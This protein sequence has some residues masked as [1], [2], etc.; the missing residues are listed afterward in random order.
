MSCIKKTLVILWAAIGLSMALSMPADAGIIHLADI[1]SE[2]L[3]SNPELASARQNIEALSHRPDQSAALPNPMLSLGLMNVPTDSFSFDNEAMTQKSI[4]LSQRFPWSG[5]RQLKRE[6]AEKDLLKG[7]FA[8]KSLEL[9]LVLEVKRSYFQLFM[10]NRA[11]EI[12]EKN[13]RLLKELVGIAETKYSVGKGIQQDVL[14]A[15]VELSRMRDR[16]ITLE[17]D[18]NTLKA[19]LNSLMNRLPQEQLGDPEELEL[20]ETDPDLER[21]QNLASERHPLL[22]AVEADVEG[23]RKENLLARKE[24]K[25]D[26]DLSMQYGQRDDGPM[27]ERPDFVSAV[28]KFSVPLWRGEKED[29]R[30]LETAARVKQGEREYDRIRNRLFF[31]AARLKEGLESRRERA[32]LFKEGIIPQ[33]KAS[34]DS[35]VAGYQVNKVDFLTLLSSQITLFNYEMEYY[36]SVSEHEIKL[37]ELEEV[38]GGD[39]AAI[40]EKMRGKKNE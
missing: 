18:R 5:K 15:Q 31:E 35:S 20:T 4:V 3:K 9:K 36:K 40:P 8:L 21:V 29:R 7:E 1:I 39:I 38:A 22:K 14:K 34:L 10:A 33:A 26:I 6:M 28:V 25:P 16:L 27:G 17:E 24:H 23:T 32:L 37:A 30:V 2:A 12:T 11:I 19:R 13:R